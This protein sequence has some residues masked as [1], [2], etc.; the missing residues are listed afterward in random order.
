M[1]E[2]NDLTKRISFY[3]TGNAKGIQAFR[4]KLINNGFSN[5]QTQTYPYWAE[6]KIGL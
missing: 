3:L 2:I 6:G 5:K 1:S 4:D